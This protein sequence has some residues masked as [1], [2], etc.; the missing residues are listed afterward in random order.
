M[1]FKSLK[2][3]IRASD[4]C[5]QNCFYCYVSKA[6]RRK[7]TNK[8]EL[9][10]LEK[11]F[12]EIL[13]GQ[14]FS[15][16]HII[17]HGGEPTLLGHDYLRRAIA[18]TNQLKSKNVSVDHSIQTNAT[19][20]SKQMVNLFVSESVGVGVSID[21]P[22]DI[23]DKIRVSWSGLSTF[24][25]TMRGI[26]KL[27]N[28][29]LKFGAICVLHRYNYNRVEEIYKFFKNIGISYQLNPFYKDEG[30]DN[31]A[32][33]QLSITP[34]QYAKALIETF[35][36][37]SND[38]EH[39]IDVSDIRDII[40]SMFIGRSGNCLYHGACHEFI[41]IATNG[42]VF[43]CDNF[44]SKNMRIGNIDNLSADDIV[45]SRTVKLISRRATML[46][47]TNCSGCRWWDI[48]HGGC[49]SKASAVFG[50]SFREDPFCGSRKALFNR[51]FQ[52][53]QSRQG[54]GY[55]RNKLHQ[56]GTF[57]S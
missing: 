3:I 26:N 46:R 2:V 55:E 39:T 45:Q 13:S 7:R 9:N 31:E 18:I 4:T 33:Q 30:V 10:R 21:A 48:C 27:R 28:A 43:V 49:C 34:E 15:H 11:F 37:Y 22:Q 12:S 38:S 29:G 53:L 6:E 23:H 47:K 17:W 32:S 25:A 52:F 44:S 19:A 51:I 24:E 41:G 20:I 36:L 56:T 14:I 35:D 57:E 1:R 54:S 5:N 40:T 50:T 16:V 8:I 42:D